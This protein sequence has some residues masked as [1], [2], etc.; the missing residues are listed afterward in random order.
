MNY[1]L[2]DE[3]NI[4]E[5]RDVCPGEYSSGTNRVTLGAYDD[6]G[7]I[8]GAISYRGLFDEADI[9]WI[10]VEPSSRRTGIATGLVN[11]VIKAVETTEFSPIVARFEEDDVSGLFSFFISMEELNVNFSHNRYV[12]Q[13]TDLDTVVSAHSRLKKH[14]RQERFFDQPEYRQRKILSELAQID[15]GYHVDEIDRWK[16]KCI[17]ELC[18]YLEIEGRLAGIVFVQMRSDNNLELA[19]LNGKTPILLMDMIGGVAEEA[20]AEYD[21]AAIYMDCISDESERLANKFFP[22][23]KCIHIYEAEW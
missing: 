17:P 21:N 5:F 9:D 10:F 11:E 15:N 12:T 13:T 22:K 20:A 19:Y 2:L 1:I 8:R 14:I 4:K 16:K 23:A 7:Y 6:D 3:N 18:R